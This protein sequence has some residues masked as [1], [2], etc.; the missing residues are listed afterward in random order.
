MK[1]YKCLWY[2]SPSILLRMRYVSD[3]SCRENQNT[4]FMFNNFVQKLFHLWDT[5]E[6]YSTARQAIDDNIISHTCFICWATKARIHTLHG[7]NGY[8]NTPQCY[9]ICTL[10]PSP[11]LG[12]KMQRNRLFTYTKMVQPSLLSGS[13]K[14]VNLWQFYDLQ[15]CSLV[16]LWVFYYYYYYYYYY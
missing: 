10:P 16:I 5:L 6:K 11:T 7:N 8:A 15:F 2:L 13:L 9:I 14:S 1:T 12:F 3:K 4:Q